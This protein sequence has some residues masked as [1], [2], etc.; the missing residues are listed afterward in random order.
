MT[1][2]IALTRAVSPA[3]AAC[4][5]T[6]LARTPIDVDL[7][8]RQHAE[9]ERALESTGCTVERVSSDASMPD[10]V[11]I[12]DA[13]IVLDELAIVSRPGA[14]SR[15]GE[16]A[17]VAEALARHRR[18]VTIDAPG[19]MDGGDV[20]SVGRT[21][22]VGRSTRTNDDGIA[23]LRAIT[24]PLGYSVHALGVPSCLHLKSALTALDDTTLLVNPNALP[25]VRGLPAGALR[26]YGMTGSPS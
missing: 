2:L 9:Y 25:A 21:I 17:A 22:F 4:E 12:E 26:Q 10:A 1:R 13:A 16:T 18:V 20:L 24:E 7:A 23:S 19:T 3:F 5:L 8:R 14:A 11:F 15:R 6:H